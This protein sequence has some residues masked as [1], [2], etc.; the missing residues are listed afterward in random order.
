MFCLASDST[1]G[2]G[3]GDG[4]P[5]DV[6]IG[7]G[8]G[9]FGSEGIGLKTG[10]GVGSAL[11]ES[12][13]DGSTDVDGS[14]EAEIVGVDISGAG[15]FSSAKVGA[16]LANTK[17]TTTKK[18][19]RTANFPF[20]VARRSLISEGMRGGLDCIGKWY[21][22]KNLPAELW[23]PRFFKVVFPHGAREEN[24]GA[25]SSTRIIEFL[26]KQARIH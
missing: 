21:R 22:G 7:S 24:T 5:L 26:G 23:Q 4:E 19:N 3:D 13:G 12:V 15:V 1:E 25:R 11:V 17:A 2:V 20:R 14:G 6:G 16:T 8:T 10:V 9:F 18:I